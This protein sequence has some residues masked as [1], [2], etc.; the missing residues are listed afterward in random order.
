[1]LHLGN[2]RTAL[3]N[4]LAARAAGGRFMLRLDDTDAARCEDRFAVAIREDLRWLGLGWDA[5]ARQS[6]RLAAYAAAADALLAAGRLYP[7]YETPEELEFR[8]RMQ[9]SQGRPPIYDRAALRLTDAQRAA[10]EAEGRRPHWRFRLDAGAAWRDGI[11]G[12][13]KVEAGAVSDP[14]LIREDGT[15]L[16]TLAS[17][18]DDAEFGVTDVI[19]GADHVTN[20]AVQ[21]EIFAALGATP[22]R[23][24]HHSLLTGP[25]GAALSKREGALSVA[26]LRAEGVEPMAV[27]SLLSALGSAR[28]VAP[29]SDMAQAVA[30]F[31]LSGFGA[32]PVV[33]DLD[34]IRRLSAEVLRR[35]DFS[36]VADRLAA[37]GIE[38]PTAALF[39]AAVRPNLDRLSDAAEWWAVVRGDVGP[40]IDA[41]DAEFCAL[42]M[43][44]LPP[45]PWGPQ[46]WGEWT[47]EMKAKTGRKG[48]ALYLP[49]RRL[50]TGR[51][52]GPDMAALMPLLEKP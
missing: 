25:G 1:M 18:V 30:G 29:L 43:G 20:T 49:L 12:P 19:R 16:Y 40:V 45:R 36:A 11:L 24:A 6:A 52:H 33:L 51:D 22:P 39:W 2:L 34:Q 48:R 13:Q 23:F 10:F 7:C 47:A 27:V 5:E 37:L 15:V 28:D 38:G 44:A 41:E 50:L 21:I 3:L 31:D 4:W 17:V 46:T 14:V 32:A 9:L 42:A 8:R 26:E 35:K